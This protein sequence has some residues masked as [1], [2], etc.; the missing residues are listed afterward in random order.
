[1][2]E[3]P[4]KKAKFVKFGV[5]KANLATLSSWEFESCSNSG[6]HQCNG[7]IFAETVAFIRTTQIPVAAENKKWPRIR[8]RFFT[9]FWLR[10]GSEEK[11]RILQLSTPL[12]PA[13]RIR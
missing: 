5:K 4:P 8:I 12:F 3:L 2:C 11:R 6:N 9:N 13:P 10:T 7:N 1:M